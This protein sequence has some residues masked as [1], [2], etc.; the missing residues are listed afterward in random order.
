MDRQSYHD[1]LEA[2]G[3]LP[4]RGDLPFFREQ[5]EPGPPG[6]GAHSVSFTGLKLDHQAIHLA[7]AVV[8]SIGF[9]VRA[10]LET[11]RAAG[12]GIGAITLS[13]GQAKNRPWVRM[14]ADITGHEL[15][16]PH[17]K[18]AELLGDAMMGMIGLGVYP[19]LGAAVGGM[20][21]I[22]ETITPDPAAH[23]EWSE[24]YA[25]YRAANQAAEGTSAELP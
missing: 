18:D 19:D 21:R 7:R 2:I 11:M 13:G 17:V 14:K 12:C 4:I 24:R 10:R 16:V 9:S 20:L 23:R 5:A 15:A 6:G 22:E 25:G 8:E 3:R 1:T